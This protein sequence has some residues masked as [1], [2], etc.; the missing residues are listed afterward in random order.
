MKTYI[1]IDSVNVISQMEDNV[2][3]IENYL[4]FLTSLLKEYNMENSKEVGDQLPLRS[5][6]LS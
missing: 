6:Y 2:F 1:S 4:V 5:E 3:E